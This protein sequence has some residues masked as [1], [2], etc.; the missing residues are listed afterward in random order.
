MIVSSILNNKDTFNSTYLDEEVYNLLLKTFI[1][2]S[3]FTYTVFKVTKK[4]IA[5]PDLISLDAYG[6]TNY[7]DI[8]CKINGISDPFTL[9]SGVYLILPSPNSITD[10]INSNTSELSFFQED[11]IS[12]SPVSTKSSQSQ[13]KANEALTGDTRFIIDKEK[14]IVI[15]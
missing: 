15:Y 8:I 2:P 13:R 11:T 10:F 9:N 4:Y 3:N 7:M 14:G 6:T 12:S 1:V 5:R